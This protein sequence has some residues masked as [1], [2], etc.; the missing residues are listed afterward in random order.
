MPAPRRRSAAVAVGT[1]ALV[2]ASLTGCAS[3]TDYTGVC[4][5]KR[6]NNRVVDKDCDDNHV[7]GG[8]HGWYY[9]PA[10]RTAPA[11]G[12]PVTGGVFTAPVG[13]SVA[14]GG[15]S[16]KGGT[17]ARGGFGGTHGSVGG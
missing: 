13:K 8:S 5:D 14:K 16:A 15:V 4:V 10:G 11:V 7:A 1:A 9:I 6:T 12:K 3:G 17:V 2:V